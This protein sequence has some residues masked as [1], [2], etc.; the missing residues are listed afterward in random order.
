MKYAGTPDRV[1]SPIRLAKVSQTTRAIRNR[2]QED[3]GALTFYY[4]SGMS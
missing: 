4:P 1:D 2:S 3:F